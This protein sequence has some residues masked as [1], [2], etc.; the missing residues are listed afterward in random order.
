MESILTQVT[1][2]HM[3]LPEPAIGKENGIPV[4]GLHRRTSVPWGRRGPNCGCACKVE[5]R[6]GYQ[7]GHR[8]LGFFPMSCDVD[9]PASAPVSEGM[10]MGWA[11]L[12]MFCVKWPFP[13]ATV[14][15]PEM[16]T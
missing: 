14:T 4:I 10:V 8:Y 12:A 11:K 13:S 5:H 6:N 3:L 7:I 16:G 9:T 15:G 2:C 1:L